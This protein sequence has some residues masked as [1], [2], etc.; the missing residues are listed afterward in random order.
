MNGEELLKVAK[1]LINIKNE[2]YSLFIDR[3]YLFS[4]S[5]MNAKNKREMKKM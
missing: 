1:I 4:S 2:I 5:E 3:H